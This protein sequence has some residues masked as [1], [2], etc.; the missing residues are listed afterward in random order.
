[1]KIETRT[2]FGCVAR[3]I[4]IRRNTI[5]QIYSNRGREREYILFMLDE[6][7]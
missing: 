2:T 4:S 7:V 1:M 6:L 5:A 3:I